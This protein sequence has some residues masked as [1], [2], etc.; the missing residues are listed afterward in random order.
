[1]TL[2]HLC[3]NRACVRRSHLQPVTNKENVLRGESILAENARKTHCKNGH[4][5]TPENTYMRK[6][7]QGGRMCKL[8]SAESGRRNRAAPK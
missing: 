8:C 6:R 4:E 3:R 2:D 5:L 7:M 1:M